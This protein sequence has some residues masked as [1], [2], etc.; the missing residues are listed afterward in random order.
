MTYV[1]LR[2]STEEEMRKDAILRPDS[3]I[4]CKQCGFVF[5]SWDKFFE[6]HKEKHPWID[7]EVVKAA[8]AKADKE[9]TSW[10]ERY[11]PG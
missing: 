6:H 11:M 5:K 2:D 9:M 10:R 8:M 1:P 3:R 4:G 7:P